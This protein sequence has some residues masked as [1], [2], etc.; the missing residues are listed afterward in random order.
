MNRIQHLQQQ[1]LTLYNAK[2]MHPKSKSIKKAYQDVLDELDREM[3][4]L[5]LPF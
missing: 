2:Q 5:P 3:Q 1:L 4:L